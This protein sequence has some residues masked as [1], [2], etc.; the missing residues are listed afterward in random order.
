M[1]NKVVKNMGSKTEVVAGRRH[2]KMTEEQK[3]QRHRC[4]LLRLRVGWL[5]YNSKPL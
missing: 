3:L 2:L 4:G 5:Q 1:F